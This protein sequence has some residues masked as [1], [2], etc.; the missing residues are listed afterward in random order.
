[1]PPRRDNLC[2][3]C[4]YALEQRKDDAPDAIRIRLA[5][6]AAK[7]A[8]LLAYYEERGLLYTID[9]NADPEEVFRRA[10]AVLCRILAI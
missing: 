4:G 7:T 8:P 1:M 3:H 6:Y 5:E 9:S 2:D 10:E